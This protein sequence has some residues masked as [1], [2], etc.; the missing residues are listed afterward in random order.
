MLKSRWL[1]WL[2]LPGIFVGGW[3]GWVHKDVIVNN[4]PTWSK[5]CDCEKPAADVKPTPVPAPVTPPT[6][7]PVIPPTPPTPAP[8]V[9]PPAWPN[10]SWMIFQDSR[11]MISC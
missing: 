7:A 4:I 10:A 3:Q 5:S 9:V 11:L 2:V 8:V 1:H 6:P